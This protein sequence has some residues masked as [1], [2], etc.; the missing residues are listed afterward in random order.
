MLYFPLSHS[1]KGLKWQLLQ[2]FIND[3]FILN[4]LI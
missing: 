2:M 4:S 1:N 3:T